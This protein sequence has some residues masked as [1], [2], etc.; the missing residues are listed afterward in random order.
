MKM[1]PPLT[2]MPLFQLVEQHPVPGDQAVV[3]LAQ[4]PDA[5]PVVHVEIAADEVVGDL[6]VIRAVADGNPAAGGVLAAVE[7]DVVMVHGDVV[8]LVV[9]VGPGGGVDQERAPDPDTS[10]PDAAIAGDPVVADLQVRRVA[11][12]HDAAVLRTGDGKAVDAGLQRLGEQI[13]LAEHEDAGALLVIQR[14]DADGLVQRRRLPGQQLRGSGGNH[15]SRLVAPVRD[16][17]AG[18]RERI[19]DGSLAPA[20]Q[21]DRLVHDDLFAVPA[22]SDQNEIAVRGRVNGRLDRTGHAA[23]AGLAIDERGHPPHRLAAADCQGHAVDAPEKRV[24]TLDAQLAGREAWGQSHRDHGVGPQRHVCG[25]DF[26]GAQEHLALRGAE[27]VVARNKLIRVDGVAVGRQRRSRA[28]VGI[29][30]GGATDRVDLD[31][32]ARGGQPRAAAVGR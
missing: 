15:G 16:L 6:V 17:G 19:D 30:H 2:V 20:L 22:R 11:V 9:G 3:A 23:A 29:L 18:V 1:P 8:V 32:A 24:G 28:I 7:Q 31:C 21:L 27:T 5:A 14:P 13:G 12:H 26:H 4:V 25:R 10:A